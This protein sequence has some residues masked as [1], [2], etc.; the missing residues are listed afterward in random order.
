MDDAGEPDGHDSPFTGSGPQLTEAAC[1]HC[2]T[3]LAYELDGHLY[4]RIIGVEYANG[5]KDRYDGVSEWQCP[6]CGIR[7][8]RWSGHVLADGE[9]E[10][11]FGV[12]RR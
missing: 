4:S 8:G 9:T 1:D 7:V 6:H 11:P 10:P 3:I 12:D 2:K 5:S